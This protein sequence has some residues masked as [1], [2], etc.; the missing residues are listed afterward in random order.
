MKSIN[1]NLNVKCNYLFK[2]HQ[3]E[4]GKTYYKIKFQMEVCNVIFVFYYT[5]EISSDLFSVYVVQNM[6]MQFQKLLISN[7]LLPQDDYKSCNLV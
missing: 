3:N 4:G 7:F 5:S 1:L 6:T 2:S